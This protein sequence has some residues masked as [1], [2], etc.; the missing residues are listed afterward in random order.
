MNPGTVVL[1]VLF[2]LVVI[3]IFMGVRLVPQGYE[4]IVQR[5][6]KYHSTLKPGL[7]FIIPY[8]DIVAY[9]LTTKDI[10]LE[11]GAQEAITNIIRH[12]NARRVLVSDLSGRG[13]I[14]YKLKQHGLADRLTEDSRR[15]LLE[16]IK[17]MEYDGYELE[18]AEGTFELLI[19][20]A[21]RLTNLVTR[22]KEGDVLYVRGPY[23]RR[24][25]WEAFRGSNIALIAGGLGLAPL[26]PFVRRALMRR[27]DFRRIDIAVGARSPE[28]LLFRDDIASWSARHDD[29]HVGV[30]V[31]AA[32]NGWGGRI[33]VITTLFDDMKTDTEDAF[34]FICGPPVMYRH[35]IRKLL[36]MGFYENHVWLTLERRMKCGIG[37][38]GNC[39]MDGLYLCQQGPLF[40][41]RE[42][43]HLKEAV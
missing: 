31:D 3:T 37:I 8:M 7:N 34:A 12:A 26:R 10:T 14:L 38:C 33:G 35:A 42:V 23:G 27:Q 18:A 15:E 24:V 32:S 22:L 29:V 17:Q 25:G 9:R 39:Q 40:S 2:A 1:A 11:I 16:R 43:R 36:A 4:F 13:N 41:Y 21:G 19:R 30:T 6:G 28:E 5:L 20:K